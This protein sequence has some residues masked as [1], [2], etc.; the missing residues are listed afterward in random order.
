[1]V[2]NEKEE[3]WFVFHNLKVYQPR[4]V[5]LGCVKGLEYRAAVASWV[6]TVS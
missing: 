2:V 1:M 5:K 6:A 3:K 4:A